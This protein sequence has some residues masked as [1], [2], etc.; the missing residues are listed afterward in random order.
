MLSRQRNHRGDDIFFGGKI[1]GERTSI[2]GGGEGCS[3][4]VPPGGKRKVR[5]PTRNR[6]KQEKDAVERGKEKPLL[7]KKKN[8]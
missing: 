2:I 6:L 7:C 5:S 1:T 4:N 3:P 8:D